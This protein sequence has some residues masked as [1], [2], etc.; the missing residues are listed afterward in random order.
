MDKSINHLRFQKEVV[1]FFQVVQEE[2]VVPE[3]IP[4]ATTNDLEAGNYC[5][6]A[7]CVQEGELEIQHSLQPSKPQ[8]NIQDLHLITT[9]SEYLK[10]CPVDHNLFLAKNPS[11]KL[12]IAA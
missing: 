2:N 3:E 9:C 5:N 11:G 12:T 4:Y 6:Q 7:L 8:Q 10:E 1:R